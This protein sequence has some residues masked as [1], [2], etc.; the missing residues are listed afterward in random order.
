MFLLLFGSFMVN[1]VRLIW[2]DSR[3]SAVRIWGE[4]LNLVRRILG[5]IAG[6]FL[7]ERLQRSY[8]L[9]IVQPCFSRVTGLRNARPKFKP[10]IVGI[11]LQFRI[12]EPKHYSR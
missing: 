12:F 9:Q 1:I 10:K 3:G 6:K 7:S 4:C 11:P 5:K 2:G 8:F